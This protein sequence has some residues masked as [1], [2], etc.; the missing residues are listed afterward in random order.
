MSGYAHVAGELFNVRRGLALDVPLGAVDF[1]EVLQD[2]ILATELWYDFLNLGF[3][4][5]PTAGFDFPCPSA[6]GGERNY[7]HVG[8]AFSVNAWYVQLRANRTFV[9]NGPMLEFTVNGN[10]IG[11]KIE[12]LPGDEIEVVASASRPLIDSS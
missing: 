2:G 12:L 4:L 6:P 11:S 3:A 7:V 9:T 8:E 10:G 1:V 5:T